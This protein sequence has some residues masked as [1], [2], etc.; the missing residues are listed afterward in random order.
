MNREIKQSIKVRKDGNFTRVAFDHVICHTDGKQQYFNAENNKIIY[1]KLQDDLGLQDLPYLGTCVDFGLRS[2]CLEESDGKFKFYVNI[3]S[4]K[5]NYK[6]FD[7]VKDA[8]DE[9]VK[10]YTDYELVSC[11]CAFKKIFY[12][13]LNL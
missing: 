2:V 6:E 4:E 1:T 9:L 3:A 13:T 10:Y 8:I 7:N 12:N 11:P 5:T